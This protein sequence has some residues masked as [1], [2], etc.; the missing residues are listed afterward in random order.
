MLRV[1]TRIAEH[2]PLKNEERKQRVRSSADR[3]T[4][5]TGWLPTPVDGIVVTLEMDVRSYTAPASVLSNA[6]SGD[7][8]FLYNIFPFSRTISRFE[9]TLDNFHRFDT[10]IFLTWYVIL[11]RYMFS[12]MIRWISI[13]QNCDDTK[14]YRNFWK[15]L[16]EVRQKV[17]R[18]EIDRWKKK[19]HCVS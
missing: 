15:F 13:I 8:E 4:V 2:L 17:K 16:R 3:L 7:T 9:T 5:N 11:S 6:R 10:W 14:S 12:L 18:K 19:W 1:K